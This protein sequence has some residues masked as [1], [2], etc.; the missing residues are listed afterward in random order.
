M[1]Y[2]I[3]I[4]KADWTPV[5]N[6]VFEDDLRDL[7]GRHSAALYLCLYDRVY[8]SPSRRFAATRSELS[9]LT[10][11][12]IRTLESCLAELRGQGLIRQAQRGVK[13]SRSQRP[14]WEVP[15]A[16]GDLRE[17]NWTPI[18]SNL[19]LKYIPAYRNAVLLPLLVYYQ[20]MKKLN[21]CWVGVPKLSAQLNWS[22]TRVR[23]SLRY[24]F[25]KENWLSLHPDLP[26]PLR[27]ETVTTREGQRS[28]RFTVRGIR[29]EEE[30]EATVMRLSTSFRRAFEMV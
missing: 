26:W 5:R 6:Q 28:R 3:E 11:I 22:E 8:Q 27:C 9:R 19:I 23:D 10:G 24:M 25:D 30:E 29:Y 16:S 4:P 18:P 12:D 15:L 14:V 20:N 17:G 7:K 1:K 21:Y 2:K 13:R